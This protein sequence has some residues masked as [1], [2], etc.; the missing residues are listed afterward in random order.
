[1]LKE[2]LFLFMIVFVFTDSA[3]AQ[4]IPRSEKLPFIGER[5]FNFYGSYLVSPTSDE[6]IQINKDRFTKI[7]GYGGSSGAE[8]VIYKGKF[9][10]PIR[11]LRGFLWKLG[12][13]SQRISPIIY[14]A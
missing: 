2:S 4:R 7:T 3:F 10:N 9:S 5:I 12:L 8:A 11:V 14:I 1:M 6:F 13:S